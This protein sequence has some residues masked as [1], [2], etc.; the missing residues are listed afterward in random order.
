M[1]PV[2]RRDFSKSLASA[3]VT[4][5]T[6]GWGKSSARTSD[7]K[8]ASTDQVAGLTLAAAAAQLRSGAMT[9]V[10]LTR[11]CLERISIYNPKLDAFITVLAEQALAQAAQLD[12]ERTAGRI[13]GPLHG[14]P[15]ALKDNIDTAGIRTTA[16]SQ[17]YDDRVP[18]ENAE[19]VR[20]LDAAGAVLIGKTNLG[21]FAGGVSYFGSVR[22]PWALDRDPNGSSSGSAA[23]VAATLVYGALGT[24]TGGSIRLPAACCG[25][26]GLKPTYGLVPI[27]GIVPGVLSLDHCG[28]ITRTVEDAAILLT[29]LAG[30]DKLD[31]SS[32]EHRKEDYWA[33]LSR[34]VSDLRVGVPRAPFFDH[35]DLDTSKAVEDAISVFAKLTGS[36]KDVRLPPTAAYTWMDLNSIGDEMY[37]YHEGLF[38]TEEVRYML[39]FHSLLKGLKDGLDNGVDS[40]SSKVSSY[41]R[42]RWDMEL[43]RRTV[44]DAFKD[45]DFVVLP[46]SRTVPGKLSEVIRLEEHPEARN[47]DESFLDNTTPFNVFGIPAIS[48]PC[49]FSRDGLPIGLMIAGPHFSE[50]KLLALAH[51]YEVETRWDLRRPTLRPNML[52]PSIR[53]KS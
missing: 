51:A 46:T 41:I 18:T 13:R 52:V 24:D 20:R 21:E 33:D 53:R 35:V 25:V 29:A 2:T 17:V 11:A 36:T 43:L 39:A 26:V 31:I 4:L 5:A 19:V 47:P 6:T 10:V 45:F 1:K 34:S 27:R 16:A 9:S 12:I 44:D 37:A 50:G 22:N 3:A 15:V 38:K 48:V 28:P 14:I 7:T 40:C 8:A 30:Y 32:V 23:A 49:G 42:H